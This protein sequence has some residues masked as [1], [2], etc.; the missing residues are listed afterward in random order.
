MYQHC[1]RDVV[2]LTGWYR[3]QTRM[4]IVTDTISLG[5]D[6]IDRVPTVDIRHSVFLWLDF[7]SIY[8]SAGNGAYTAISIS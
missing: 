3:V 6:T 7:I 4:G 5:R 2:Y 8:P 1:N